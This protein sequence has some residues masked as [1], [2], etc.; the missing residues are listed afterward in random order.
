MRKIVFNFFALLLLLRPFPIVAQSSATKVLKEEQEKFYT[1][2]QICLLLGNYHES[3][4]INLLYGDNV[5][6]K[7]L[8][9][10]QRAL[11]D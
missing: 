4:F 2:N 9:R 6:E 1:A 8:T 11:A 5:Y 3:E 10:R 7:P